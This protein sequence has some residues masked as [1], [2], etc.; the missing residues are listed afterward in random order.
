[1]PHRSE[2]ST[3]DVRGARQRGDV[4][5]LVAALSG[6]DSLTRGA[7]ARSLGHTKAVKPLIRSLR[8][9][10]DGLRVNALRA[11]RRIGDESAI[12]AVHKLATGDG[13]L[14]VRVSA[15]LTLGSLGDRRAIELLASL[16]VD[17][18]LDEAA[19]IPGSSTLPKTS[20]SKLGNGAANEDSRECWY[21]QS[22][23]PR[24]SAARGS[25]DECLRAS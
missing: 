2:R 22:D 23:R 14:G 11:L 8:S 4:A 12:P 10:D 6:S 17:P 3:V 1:V 9:S 18:D 15:M 21:L 5:Y 20:P 25:G 19:Q 7:A 24:P 13:A 16:L